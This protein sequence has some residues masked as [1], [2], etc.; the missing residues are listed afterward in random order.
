MTQEAARV[1]GLALMTDQA[2]A[3][4]LS[5]ALLL[6]EAETIIGGRKV[7]RYLDMA[8]R[9]W[10]LLF[11]ENIESSLT[12]EYVQ[13]IFNFLQGQYQTLIKLADQKTSSNFW[14]NLNRSELCDR[15][16]GRFSI[17]KTLDGRENKYFLELWPGPSLGSPFSIHKKTPNKSPFVKPA[18]INNNNTSQS[19][20]LSPPS[21]EHSGTS[22]SGSVNH[23]KQVFG[24]TKEDFESESENLPLHGFMI[25]SYSIWG[26]GKKP[27]CRMGKGFIL[28]SWAPNHC[29]YLTAKDLDAAIL[30]P[31][32]SPSPP[33]FL[34]L[35]PAGCLQIMKISQTVKQIPHTAFGSKSS[36]NQ[37]K[38]VL[39][40]KDMT[41]ETRESLKKSLDKSMDLRYAEVI[42][43]FGKLLSFGIVDYERAFTDP[44]VRVFSMKILNNDDDEDACSSSDGSGFLSRSEHNEGEGSDTGNSGFQA[45]PTNSGCDSDDDDYSMTRERIVNEKIVKSILQDLVSDIQEN[46]EKRNLVDTIVDHLIDEVVVKSTLKKRKHSLASPLSDSK[47]EKTSPP[48]HKKA[49]NKD[50][51][52]LKEG[53]TFEVWLYV[54]RHYIGID[55]K[56]AKNP[57]TF[58]KENLRYLTRL[59]PNLSE[60]HG[61]I[62]N[63]SWKKLNKDP[64]AKSYDLSHKWPELQHYSGEPVAKKPKIT[65]TQVS[66]SPTS[67]STNNNLDPSSPS[68]NSPQISKDKRDKVNIGRNLVEIKDVVDLTKSKSDSGCCDDCR[69]VTKMH[70]VRMLT[71]KYKC[72]CHPCVLRQQAISL[73]RTDP[74]KVI[75]ISEFKGP[76]DYWS[77]PWLVDLYEDILKGVSG[78]TQE[79]IF[80]MT[81]SN[82]IMNKSRIYERKKREQEDAARLS[83]KY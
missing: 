21:V 69:Y 20:P 34:F 75:K 73:G 60:Y 40:I 50:F 9:E 33:L 80:E 68:C 58:L 10:N 41:P 51:D 74:Y 5:P 3:A 2:V 14:Y 13:R 11:K 19:T 72:K 82:E 76:G 45:S 18:C 31:E 24:P 1:T 29:L 71:G 36:S 65:A 44:G 15:F 32:T 70:K 83:P 81:G 12:G 35:S 53:E 55:L 54:N 42:P 16:F 30:S 63:K 48:V 52:A 66:G 49:V 43:T 17:R 67:Y 8:A 25:G 28:L 7:G 59:H 47:L 62:L 39:N 46:A 6:W 64:K 57:E 77:Q 78:L 27:V 22:G 4:V 61:K 56:V 23:I 38:I 37:K 26:Q 79:K